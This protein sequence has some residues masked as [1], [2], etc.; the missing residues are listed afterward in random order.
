[1]GKWSAAKENRVGERLAAGLTRSAVEYANRN[2][3]NAA[4]EKLACEMSDALLAYRRT[5]EVPE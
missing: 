1:M 4:A 3:G 2:P 5:G